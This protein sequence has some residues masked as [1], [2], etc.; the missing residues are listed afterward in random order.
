MKRNRGSILFKLL[1][2][3]VTIGA[4][5]VVL[6]HAPVGCG[7]HDDG[8]EIVAG[9]SLI[10]DIVGDLTD[11]AVAAHTLLPSTSCPSQ[12]D[13]KAADIRLLQQ[14]RL[15]LLHAWQL[16]LAN[17]RRVV[18]AAQVPETR[19]RVVD[20]SGNWMLPDTQQTAARTLAT[21]L[22]AHD[23]GQQSAIE[24]RLA[25]RQ[26]AVSAAA[27]RARHRLD[28]AMP[29]APV[30]LSNVMQ[31]PFAEWMGFT[32]VESFGRPED[33]SVA[34]AE[35]LVRLG[36]EQGV[37]IVIDNLQSGGLRMS[38]TLARDIGAAHVI[39]SNFPGG[40]PDT[41]DWESAFNENIERLLSVLKAM[42]P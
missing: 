33:W 20:V 35:R 19:R 22:I 8:P 14:A 21:L 5:V 10:A 24:A 4:L 6:L 9:T 34:Q 15:V 26:A 17:I 11:A 38:E 16:E 41:P 18:E 1:K 7:S 42:A 39:L 2:I 30:V 27:E 31:A 37:V 25:T 3:V 36:R 40:F 32:V 12:F 29:A 28:A 13:L 23:P